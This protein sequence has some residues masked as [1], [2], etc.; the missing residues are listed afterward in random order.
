MSSEYVCV[1][2]LDGGGASG[3]KERSK[4]IDKGKKRRVLEKQI[5]VF[6]ISATLGNRW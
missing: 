5:V 4:R 2:L 1:L 6:L 3:G